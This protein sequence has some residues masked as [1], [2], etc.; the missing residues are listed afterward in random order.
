MGADVMRQ[1]GRRQ[2][3]YSVNSDV[4]QTLSLTPQHLGPLRRNASR[5]AGGDARA[6][7]LIVPPVSIAGVS[8]A[9]ELDGNADGNPMH[10]A[11]F[12]SPSLN[13]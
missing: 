3:K 9:T 7:K 1:S 6:D 8:R 13:L 4:S 2:P 5:W 11:G 10:F 12:R